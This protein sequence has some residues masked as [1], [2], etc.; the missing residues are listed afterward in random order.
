MRC[1]VLCGR[2][3]NKMTGEIVITAAPQ[4]STK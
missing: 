4:S 1:S 3:H 2:G